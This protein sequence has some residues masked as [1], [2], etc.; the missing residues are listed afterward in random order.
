M[1]QNKTTKSV[2]G[3]RPLWQW[4]LLYVIVGGIVYA[5]V[6]YF[7]GYKS[8]SGYNVKTSSAPTTPAAQAPAAQAPAAQTVPAAQAAQPAAATTP[9]PTP[10]Q[11]PMSSSGGGYKW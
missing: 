1:D 4:V 9:T 2:Y 7:T 8:A 6:Y 10:A 5:A 11:T 3:K